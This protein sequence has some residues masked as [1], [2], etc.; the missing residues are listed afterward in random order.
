MDS[1]QLKIEFENSLRR[2]SVTRNDT[3]LA[4]LKTAI[5]SLTGITNGDCDVK[6]RDEEDD[7]ITIGS[8][9]E[10]RDVLADFASSS[11]MLRL[12]VTAKDAA[13]PTTAPATPAATEEPKQQPQAPKEPEIPWIH[14]ARSLAQP[15]VVS[16]V[17]QVLQSPII[18]EAVNRAAR[19]YVD[20]KGDVMIAG[21][22]ASQQIPLLL[23]LFA[24]LLDELPVLKDLQV[25]V[26]Q[27]W[28]AAMSGGFP[29]A[30]MGPFPFFHPRHHPHHPHPHHHPHP[31]PPTPPCPPHHPHHPPH[32][33]P[34]HPHHHGGG[35]SEGQGLKHFGVF[36]DGCGSDEELKKAS[37]AAGHQTR[38]GFIRGLRYKSDSVHDFD[39]CESCK[40]T[41]RFPDRAYGPFTPI[42]PPAD[43]QKRGG[44]GWWG[45]GRCGAAQQG[46]WRAGQQQQAP[47]A[48]ATGKTS[49]EP[50]FDF[51]DAIRSALTRGSEAL[52][53]ATKNNEATKDF[54]EIARAIAESLKD[55]K[56]AEATAVEVKPT[57]PVEASVEVKPTAPVEAQSAEDSSWVPV[58]T[59]AEPSAPAAASAD[60]FVKWT[61]Q[62][63]QLEALG[64]DKL[65]TYIIFLEEE[66]G[67]LD[68]VV[69]RIVSRDL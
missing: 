1:V 17:Q 65:E 28:S 43:Q 32:H 66:K 24:E 39:L 48:A 4:K 61:T 23:G 27:W 67:D 21:L 52:V 33:H 56:T 19:G 51:M 18:T 14:L 10:L 53:E 55:N 41:D 37:I 38:R 30:R 12:I 47:E 20:S 8:D 68:R 6:Y 11:K 35:G 42:Q 62:L 40:Q 44:R 16:R 59:P 5:L 25:L 50:E 22:M 36:C 58:A 64:F 26:M 2:L 54:S 31:V 13:V 3:T 29:H 49:E 63:S 15:E 60:P 34:H 57:A 46:N 45:G 69:S 7:L 9:Q